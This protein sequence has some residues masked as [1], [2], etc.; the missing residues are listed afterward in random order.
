MK[1]LVKRTTAIIC[2][3]C[4]FVG[5]GK[6]W[7]YLLVDDVNSYTRIMMHQLYTSDENI[8]ILFVGSS[9]VYR[10]FIPEITDEGF[11]CHT[12]NAGSSSQYMD[13]SLAIIKEAAKTNDIKHIYLELYYGVTTNEKYIERTEL[14]STYV[15]SDYMKF[16]LNKIRYMMK[17]SSKDFWSNSFFVARRNWQNFFDSDYVKDLLTRKSQDTYRNYEYDKPEGAVE[18]YVD[19]GFVANNNVVAEDTFF[20]AKAYD[21]VGNTYDS[22]KGTDWEKSLIEIVSFCNRKG[23]GLTFFMAPEPEWTIAG[24]G[25][26]SEYHD[27]ID[28]IAQECGVAFYDFNLCRDEVFDTNNR[29]LFMDEDHLNTQGAEKFSRLF[30]DFFVGKYVLSDVLYKSLEEKLQDKNIG[31]YG[32]ADQKKDEA[33]G[34]RRCRII[35]GNTQ[36]YEYKIIATTNEGEQRIVQDFDNNTAFELPIDERGMLKIMWRSIDNGEDVQTVEFSY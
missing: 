16:S 24:T 36:F 15:I 4:L 22:L 25:N 7:R 11:G 1:K 12:F 34:I 8:D 28:R 30:S 23:I 26:Y 9:H 5:N 13:G 20:N 17:A 21:G 35:S 33:S 14:T 6:L 19:R 18:Y 27:S 31:F 2:F 3:I 10:T 29:Q 32:I